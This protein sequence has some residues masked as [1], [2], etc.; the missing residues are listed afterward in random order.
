MYHT[1]PP[2][3]GPFNQYWQNSIWNNVFNNHYSLFYVVLK[4]EKSILYSY[5]SKWYGPYR[6]MNKVV[7][8][9][10]VRPHYWKHLKLITVSCPWVICAPNT[11]K[12]Q[13]SLYPGRPFIVGL[14]YLSTL[15]L[16]QLS[17][18]ACIVVERFLT[19]LLNRVRRCCSIFSTKG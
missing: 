12:W 5:K 7:E 18:N 3:G 1:N 6:L 13:A 10:S 9:C 2:I 14:R 15:K 4:L 16:I 17:T 19:V 8:S 11:G